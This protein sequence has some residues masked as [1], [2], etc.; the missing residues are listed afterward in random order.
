MVWYVIMA[1]D[2]TDILITVADLRERI[3]GPSNNPNSESYVTNDQIQDIIDLKREE[4]EEIVERRMETLSNDE[5]L[6]MDSV[7]SAV[8]V[9]VTTGAVVTIGSIPD[10]NLPVVMK[11]HL[12][13]GSPLTLDTD[14]HGTGVIYTADCGI[15][16]KRYSI[17]GN[18]VHTLPNTTATVVMYLPA[19]D[20]VRQ[21]LIADIISQVNMEIV[22]EASSMIRSRIGLV[23]GFK[24]EAQTEAP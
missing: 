19:K 2:F 11:A 14:I 3:G 1:I 17:T 16:K 24:V 21:I 23:Q 10:D 6:A 22:K 8:N 18:V 9:S 4:A 12:S 5:L 13:D 7:F 20:E 15:V